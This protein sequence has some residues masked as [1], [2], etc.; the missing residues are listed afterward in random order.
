MRR[1]P[2]GSLRP[3][4]P[5]PPA[6]SRFCVMSCQGYPD[7]GH[8][9]GHNIYPS[10][11]ALEPSFVCLTGDV[12]YYDN[13]PPSAVTAELA[14]L[15]WQRMFSLPRQRELLRNTGS[16]WLKDD[17]DTLKDDYVAGSAGRCVDVRG[18]PANLSR[19][20][21][22]ERA[23]AT[24][25]S[26]GAAICRSGS[27]TAATTA[28]RTRCRTVPTRRSGVRSRSSGSSAPSRPATPRGKCS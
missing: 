4:A 3:R 27:P 12:V 9:D 24:A 16:Y 25:R 8:R 7:R 26:A 19:A 5:T 20:D 11:L 22:D 14:R 21:A 6:I 2:A 18:R 15:H 23:A 13:D 1:S 28:R 10:M 17:H